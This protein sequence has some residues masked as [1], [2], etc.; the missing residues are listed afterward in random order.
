MPAYQYRCEKCESEIEIVKSIHDS[1][2]IEHCD[3]CQLALTRVFTP[4][5]IMGAA[6]QHA[7]YNPGLGVVTRNKEHRAEIADRRGLIELGNETQKA[8][9]RD[10]VEAKAKERQKEWDNL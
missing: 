2:R 3:V 6:V 9:Q 4:F 5:H 1:A 7:E 8:I 10:T